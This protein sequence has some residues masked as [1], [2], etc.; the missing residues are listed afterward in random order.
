MLFQIPTVHLVIALIVVIQ[1]SVVIV[2]GAALIYLRWEFESMRKAEVGSQL[3][4][5]GDPAST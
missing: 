1:A 2:L 3:R 5:D 4:K